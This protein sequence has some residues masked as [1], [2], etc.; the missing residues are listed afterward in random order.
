MLTGPTLF[1][2]AGVSVPEGGIFGFEPGGESVG[3]SDTSGATEEFSVV[4]Q[5]GTFT[6]R[7][8]TGVTVYGNGK[9]TVIAIGPLTALNQALGTLSYTPNPNFT[10]QDP[11]VMA[12]QN[13][14]NNLATAATFNITVTGNTA[15]PSIA[16][17]SAISV[18]QGGGFAFLTGNTISVT[19]VLGATEEYSIVAQH[20]T[21]NFGSTTGLVVDGNGQGTVVMTGTVL[22]LNA[23]LAALVYTPN[24]GFAGTD[25]LGMDVVNEGNNLSKYAAITVTTT[26]SNVPPTL[27]VPTSQGGFTG[28]PL[29]LSGQA[30][31]IATDNTQAIEYFSIVAQDGT[32]TFGSTTGL[33]VFG[34]GKG[35]VV[36]S[37]TLLAL[38]AA[39]PTLAYQS[40]SGFVGT[41]KLIMDI[42]NAGN[43]L[44]AYATLDLFIHTQVI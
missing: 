42:V 25:T 8:T 27:T 16:A 28:V 5:H 41:D 4:A 24:S 31:I 32:L 30:T 15:P 43:N 34:N 37:G 7:S 36:V 35:T 26:T 6:F 33:T 2:P 11:V 12:V 20:G 40:N 38:N 19:D 13:A 23:A 22:A 29:Q 21:L 10:G 14:G 18:A 17:P 9:G 44:A 1:A 3:V 39:L